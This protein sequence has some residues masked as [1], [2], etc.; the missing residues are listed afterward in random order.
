MDK[1]C[2]EMNIVSECVACVRNT[3]CNYILNILQFDLFFTHQ[4]MKTAI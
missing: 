1:I 4:T 3:V 2:Y